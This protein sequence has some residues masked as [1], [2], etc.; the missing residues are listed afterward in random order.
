MGDG[1]GLAPVAGWGVC[2]PENVAFS[3]EERMREMTFAIWGLGRSTSMSGCRSLRESSS[4][5]L[6]LTCAP[7]P[8]W[9]EGLVPELWVSLQEERETYAK[10]HTPR[11]F[12]PLLEC[13]KET[14]S[15]LWLPHPSLCRGLREGPGLSGDTP[16]AAILLDLLRGVRL[17]GCAGDTIVGTLMGRCM[18]VGPGQREIYR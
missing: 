10:L 2:R 17:E 1:V 8:A 5:L 12:I 7:P 3:R 13:V 16:A 18:A 11:N 14:F 9:C 6:K 15:F 4:M